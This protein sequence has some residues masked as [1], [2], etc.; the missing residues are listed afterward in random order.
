MTKYK[1]NIMQ[2]KIDVLNSDIALREFNC[3]AAEKENIALKKKIL[4]LEDDLYELNQLYQ[5][6]K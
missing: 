1:Q 5:L 2:N 6:L 3:K 4:K